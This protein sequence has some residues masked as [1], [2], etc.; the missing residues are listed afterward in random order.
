MKPESG[1][2]LEGKVASR[3]CPLCGHHEIGFVTKKG[4]FHPLRPG[5]SIRLE[6]PVPSA[7]SS[8]APGET[9]F[10][11]TEQPSYDQVWIP[12]PL[13][14][15]TRLRRK[16]GVMIKEHL[17]K[18]AM[19]GSLYELAYLEKLERL[20]EKAYDVPLPVTLDRFFNAPH[21]ASGNSR[22]IA[23]GLLREL[24]EIQ[25]PAV[26]VAKWLERK[27]AQSLADLV[28]P[29]ATEE[30]GRE[31]ASDEALKQELERLTLEEFLGML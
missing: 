12:E 19:S 22:Q 13:R 14:G 16:Y 28:A 5:T 25:R 7:A 15:D 20:I 26:L 17:V 2:F 4:E 3:Q 31:P 18:N 9:S 29:K 21:L 24:E 23:E 6:A 1:N 11:K 10:P 8:M 27:D 30:L